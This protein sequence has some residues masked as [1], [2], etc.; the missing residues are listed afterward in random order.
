[1]NS[2]FVVVNDENKDVFVK[3]YAPWCGHCQELAPKWEK[4]A[5]A[6]KSNPNIVIAKFDATKNEAEG[7]QVE[8]FPTLKFY[9]KDNKEGV[10]YDGEME[11]KDLKAWLEKNSPVLNESG[12]G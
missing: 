7:V 6:F 8:Q 1:M 2:I 11:T 10:D 12:A 5:Q 4:L 3:Y 9:P